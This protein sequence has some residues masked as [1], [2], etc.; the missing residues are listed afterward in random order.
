MEVDSGVSGESH[1]GDAGNEASVGSIVVGQEQVF[2]TEFLDGVPE[3]MEFCR[4][5][6]VGAFCA[7][8]VMDLGQD[9]AAEPTF[10]AT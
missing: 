10:T 9:G 5:I 7:G 6:Y 4:V 2:G 3:R 8:L 1:F